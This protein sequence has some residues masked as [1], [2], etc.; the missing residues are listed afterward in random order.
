MKSEKIFL[1]KAPIFE[2][3][4]SKLY[5]LIYLISYVVFVVLYFVIVLVNLNAGQQVLSIFYLIYGVVLL[6]IPITKHIIQKR[7]GRLYVDISDE[8]IEVKYSYYRPEKG[9]SWNDIEKIRFVESNFY[10]TSK[11]GS[12]IKFKAPLEKYL[13]LREKIK[14]YANRFNVCLEE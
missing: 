6:S 11:Q 14:G 2:P 5:E 10:I 13:D 3:K 9:Y 1:D 12:E 7:H 8:K 4:N